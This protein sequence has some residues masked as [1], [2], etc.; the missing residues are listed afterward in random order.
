MSFRRRRFQ[1]HASAAS[2]AYSLNAFSVRIESDP[3][4]IDP[5][6]LALAAERHE[7]FSTLVH[8]YWH[9]L[10]NL[11]TVAGFASFEL[12]QNVLA[13]FSETLAPAGNGRSAGSDALDAP[14]REALRELLRMQ[15]AYEGDDG[16]RGADEAV[17]FVVRDVTEDAYTLVRDG[18]DVPVTDV[19]L[20]LDVEWEDGSSSE[21]DLVFGRL[22]LEEGI[23]YE[24][25][26]MVAAGGDGGAAEDDAPAFPYYALRRL[27]SFLC[28]E[29]ITRV[30][31][32]ALATLALLSTDPPQVFVDL[33]R[34]YRERRQAGR[35]RAEALDGVWQSL[36]PH[37]EAV[38]RA[39][40]EHDLPSVVRMHVGRG[41]LQFATEYLGEQYATLLRRRLDDPLFDLRA[42]S[43]NGLDRAALL[44]LI[45]EVLP[46]DTLQ[47]M[48]GGEDAL[49]RDALVTF[50]VPPE[51]WAR[52]GY[53]P[54]DFL[55]TL[56][57]QLHYL[58]ARLCGGA[59]GRPPGRRATRARDLAG[60]WEGA[61]KRLGPLVR[62]KA[63]TRRPGRRPRLTN[64]D[65][66]SGAVPPAHQLRQPHCGGSA[67][68]RLS[69]ER[70]QAAGLDAVVPSLR[71][72]R[73]LP[74]PFVQSI[75]RRVQAVPRPP[76][77]EPPRLPPRLHPA[78]PE[79]SPSRAGSLRRA[80]GRSLGL[81]PAG[82]TDGPT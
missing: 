43:R 79:E 65:A 9:Y 18:R 74:G 5:E 26:R 14:R 34:D 56:E 63:G 23:A 27:A 29:G 68:L 59:S 38:V 36:R 39:I 17:D 75:P 54:N 67:R 32:V 70:L 41:M 42:F 78:A 15:G 47:E 46:C 10:Q 11:S 73:L 81:A 49:G 61:R 21:E 58:H 45:Q 69:G 4:L 52:L 53:R 60:L 2:G 37:T 12:I 80:P 71:P 6:T 24:V 19:L 8:E 72:G 16:P 25:D 35:P 50:G 7:D 22:C 64:H 31:T 1:R 28:P 76:R 77:H 44:R 55:R 82:E 51:R 66:T 33:T 48:P 40:L 62:R 3:P 13:V 30:E 57:C 20:T